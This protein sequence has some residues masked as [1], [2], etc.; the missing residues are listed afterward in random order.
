MFGLLYETPVSWAEKNIAHMDILLLDQAHLEKKAASIAMSF[1]FRFPDPSGKLEVSSGQHEAL[2]VVARE[3]LDHFEQ[4]MQLMKQRGVTYQKQQA[5]PYA[6]RLHTIARPSGSER[7]LDRLLCCA[8]IEARSCERIK[9]LGQALAGRDD[10]LSQFYL[11]L[12][13]SEAQHFDLYVKMAEARFSPKVVQPRLEEIMQHEA[14][15]LTQAPDVPRL[16][17]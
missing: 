16:H 13:H 9:L 3:E 4:V 12:V 15:V 8:V 6:E 5:S 2:S 11:S 17:N 10:E 14:Q 7:D 1:M